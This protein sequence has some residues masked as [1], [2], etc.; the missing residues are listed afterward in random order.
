MKKKD[1]LN[2]RGAFMCT[3]GGHAG[4]AP[5]QVPI[6]GRSWII[7]LSSHECVTLPDFR[8]LNRRICAYA[9]FWKPAPGR[10]RVTLR[11]NRR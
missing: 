1:K 3:L 6:E 11:S 9:A 2:T 5:D 8:Q 7:L 4:K 10:M